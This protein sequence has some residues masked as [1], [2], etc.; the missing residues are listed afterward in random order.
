MRLVPS[1]PHR[2]LVVLGYPGRLHGRRHV[3]RDPGA[4][5]DRPRRRS[6]TCW[7]SDMKKKDLHA[8]NVEAPS[9]GGGW[10]LVEFGGA[11]GAR[12]R[13][14]APRRMAGS[15]RP[16]RDAPSMKLFDDPS[17]SE[18]RLA[19]ARVRPRRHGAGAR[20]AATPGRAGRTRRS[21]PSG[22]APICASCGALFE[23]YGYSVRPLRPLRPGLR[24]RA[25]RLRPR[26]GAGHREV[27]RLHR[28]GGGPGAALRRLALGRARRRPVARR[29]AAE[30]V[31]RRSWSQAFREFK[32]I[33]DPAGQDE[34]GQGRRRLPR[35]IENLR[36]G[37]A[38][39]PPSLA[40][41]L[42]LP[43]ATTAASP[44][45]RCAASAWASAAGRDGGTMCPSYRV[46]ARGEALDAR[47]R[48]AAVRDAGGRSAA[49]GWRDEQ[50][51]R[52]S[53]SAWPAR[54]ARSECPVERGHGDLQGRVPL[55]LLRRAAAAALR[56]R[57]RADLLVG[58]PGLARARAGQ[59]LHPDTS[60]AR[61]AKA[62]AGAAPE[63]RLPAFAAGPFKT[64][65]LQ[66]HAPP[67]TG[68]RENPPLA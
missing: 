35:R 21:R 45:P 63:R 59:P 38:Y 52:R 46:D 42:P 62:L 51:R 57:L 30:D 5:A 9:R 1:P 50:S 65:F 64:W 47:P 11:T 12:R 48:P 58:A 20:P 25:D 68:G 26:H 19:G 55:P 32:A 56:L 23:Q 17:G 66:R 67:R 27:P 28:R 10:L 36:L 40:H 22:W 33:W 7:S 44:A 8:P 53:T 37:A 4:R 24:P 18:G 34:P 49:D 60:A 13:P 3:P 15:A 41:A 6:T 54:A 43:G 61:R 39:Q 2:V 16:G 14:S 29:A 31:R